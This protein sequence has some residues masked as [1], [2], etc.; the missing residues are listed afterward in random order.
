[1][2]ELRP[3]GGAVRVHDVGEA[4]QALDVVV[5]VGAGL[6]G[7]RAA[8]R[9]D[10]DRAHQQQPGTAGGAGLVVRE[11]T[12][13]DRAAGLGEIV[14]HRA[15]DHAVPQRQRADRGRRREQRKRGGSGHRRSVASRRSCAR[16]E[17]AGR[18]GQAT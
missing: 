8:A 2:D 18:S 7:R 13:G 12:F 4:A 14:A 15:H 17:P 10:P 3:D 5:E 6:L 16:F 9:V 11:L 1:M